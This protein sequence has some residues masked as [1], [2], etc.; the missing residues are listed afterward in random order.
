MIQMPIPLLK[1]FWQKMVFDVRNNGEYSDA[2]LP[3]VKHIPLTFSNEYL[4]EFPQKEKFYLRCAGGYPSVIAP[5]ILKSRGIH[6]IVD[7]AGGFA[8]IKN[9]DI[10]V[11]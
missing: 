9:T 3:T 8:A 6:N 5:S 10:E 2:H 4:K 1:Q 11:V 7:V